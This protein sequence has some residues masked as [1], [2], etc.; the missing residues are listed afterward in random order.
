MMQYIW[1][2]ALLGCSND[3]TQEVEEE[4]YKSQL[5]LFPP[6]GGLG[7]TVDVAIEANR[8]SFGLR[9]T[10]VDFGDGITVNSVEVDDGWHLRAQVSIDPNADLGARSVSITS[11]NG[12]Y[13]LEDSFSVVSESFLIDPPSAKM[14]EL[15]E[16]G[17]LGRNTIFE[18]GRTW[19]NFGDG[20][21][22]LDFT[23]L[24]DTLA[25]ATISVAPDASPG[26][27]NVTIDSGDGNYGV[28]YDGFKVDRVGLAAS[29]DPEIAEQG[30]MVEF[31]IRAKGT[32]FL[33]SN[34]RIIFFDRFGENIDRFGIFVD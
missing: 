16:V 18:P 15:V 33:S 20:I 34:P 7:T 19:P 9:D 3:K 6:A 2:A 4:S 5:S 14:G 27:R 13:T 31:T 25:E 8:T 29:F 17:I 28:L 22:V 10:T 24:S 26:W 11:E 32:D 12:S 30:K 1:F 23:V 21:E